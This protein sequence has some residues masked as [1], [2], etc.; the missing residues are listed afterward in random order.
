MDPGA[1]AGLLGLPDATVEVVAQDLLSK[2]GRARLVVNLGAD[3][4]EVGAAPTTT[5]G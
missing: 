1:T 2:V 3:S 5:A 4:L